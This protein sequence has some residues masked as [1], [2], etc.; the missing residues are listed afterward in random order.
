MKLNTKLLLL[1]S[2]LSFLA[3]SI[4]VF[5]IVTINFTQKNLNMLIDQDVLFL[6][7]TKEVYTQG[8]QRGQA[9]RNIILNAQDDKARENF[10]AASDKSME[11]IEELLLSASRY[12]LEDQMNELKKFTEQDI[13]LQQEA[14]DLVEKSPQLAATLIKE[15]ETP[16]WRATK[17][18]YFVVEEDIQSMFQID[19]IEQNKNAEYNKAVLLILLGV[20]IIVSASIFMYMRKVITTPI[21]KL[22][23]QVNEVASGDLTIK[24]YHVTS[25]DELSILIASFD[26]MVRE[27]QDIVMEVKD[28]SKDV[29]T[30]AADLMVNSEQTTKATEHISASMEDL[31]VGTEEEV[32]QIKNTSHVLVNMSQALHNILSNMQQMSDSANDAQGKS[33]A[34]HAALDSMIEQMNSI[35]KNVSKLS[36]FI[37]GLGSRSREIENII[38]VI[39]SIADQTNLL[40]L[41][42]AIEAARAGEHGKGFAVV[43]D[44]VKK[45]AEQTTTSAQQISDLVLFIQ[46]ETEEAVSSM[47]IVTSEVVQGMD[48]VHEAD[49]SFKRIQSSVDEVSTECQQ[50]STAIE[51]LTSDAKQ[52]VQSI[53]QVSN[54]VETSSMST[55]SVLAT[56]EEQLAAMEEI[57]SS[58][59]H[60]AN[61]AVELD[62]AIARFK[63]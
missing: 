40:A 35:Q 17:E 61:R 22:S 20:F 28:S 21:V 54:I 18:L 50:I 6:S 16:V 7:Q 48:I 56:T 4:I 43:A 15:Q 59:S 62:T 29:A 36:E 9:V 34:G 30:S 37:K 44:E 53:D 55:Q 47:E 58:A 23:T 24:T 1:F 5:S 60:L 31:A 27:L 38:A 57:A 45:L 32:R 51:E 26:Q 3:T 25:K 63:V 8:L 33:T 41:N 52:V 46:T 49:E 12:G 42:A 10:K 19:K 14:I 2:I 11:I 13:Q 39:T